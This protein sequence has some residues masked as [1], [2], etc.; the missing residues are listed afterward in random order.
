MRPIF[1]FP[2]SKSRPID[3]D[4]IKEDKNNENII[5]R[6]ARNFIADSNITYFA[7]NGDLIPRTLRENG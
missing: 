5:H 6:F 4:P 3:A 7:Q 1:S 2:R